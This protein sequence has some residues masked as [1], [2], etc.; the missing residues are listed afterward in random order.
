MS[1]AFNLP[2]KQEHESNVE[3]F[4]DLKTEFRFDLS[5][6]VPVEPLTAWANVLS[7]K[8]VEPVSISGNE[9]PD[10]ISIYEVEVADPY[11]SADPVGYG[12]VKDYVHRLE[13]ILDEHGF[14]P[15][16]QDT[17]NR[18]EALE[19]KDYNLYTQA[20][21][22]APEVEAVGLWRNLV[23]TA[24]ALSYLTQP[25]SGRTIGNSYGDIQITA[26]VSDESA[27]LM[28]FV[29]D[30]VAIRGR[31]AAMQAIAESHLDSLTESN[32]SL[33]WLSLASGTAEPS[34]AAAKTIS[35]RNGCNID[36][37]LVDSSSRAIEL[38]EA[39]AQEYDFTEH[40][41]AVRANIL[42]PK[43]RDQLIKKTG[44][45]VQQYD[46]VEAMGFQEYLPQD[47]DELGAYKGKNL[48]PASEFVKNALTYVKP[49]GVF[50]SGNMVI[51]RTESTFVFGVVDWPLVN[52]R[53]EEQILK[54]Y[55][56]AGVL[57]DPDYQV[58]L[59]RVINSFSK[60]HIYD[61]VTVE[62]KPK[63]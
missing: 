35:D 41:N 31:A 17:N 59:F 48:P 21:I 52:A 32:P 30:A 26:K 11:I 12:M 43:L 1:H 6:H 55:E 24:E 25:K 40:F 51:P 2:P 53:S 62:K 63:R 38:I 60:S 16:S 5:G 39:T 18:S 23:P 47:G 56:E 45:E 42:S 9:L 29:E 22:S 4:D 27:I 8:R 54:I 57:S 20:L 33:K 10:D 14:D 15:T 13:N 34:L 36:L 19:P 37:T 28:R 46:V 61:I 44:N 58:S 3:F 49:G 50:I 7:A